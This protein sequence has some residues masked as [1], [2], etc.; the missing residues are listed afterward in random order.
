MLL[1]SALDQMI[2]EHDLEPVTTA[3]YQRGVTRF[4]KFLVRPAKCDDLTLANV[5]AWLAWLKDTYAHGPISV[6][7]HR[8]AMCRVWRYCVD[9]LGVAEDFQAHR[10]RQPK[11]PDR[12]VQ[13]WSLDEIATLLDAAEEL[14]G[15]LSN[16]MLAKDFLRAWIWLGYETGFRPGDIRELNWQDVDFDQQTVTLIQHKTGNM[17]T[18]LFGEETKA[19]LT[20]LKEY[21]EAKVFPLGKSGVVRWQRLL[22]KQAATKRFAKQDRQGLG[23]LRRCHATEVYRQH[24]VAAAAAS[25]GHVGGTRTVMHHYI[26]SRSIRSGMLPP[27]PRSNH[28]QCEGS[29]GGS[30]AR[31]A[32]VPEHCSAPER[33][34]E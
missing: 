14:P 26:D 8:S 9:P 1:Q 28:V 10:I 22:F 4:S 32:S 34:R 6:R 19:A 30:A 3:Q 29:R 15:T 13:A 25:L 20:T 16:G 33:R 7:N 27:A 21:G 24:G 31:E 18:A 12:R 2:A 11:L 23:T 5:N 17:H